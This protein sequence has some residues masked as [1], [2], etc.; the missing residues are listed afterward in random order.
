[1]DNVAT[2]MRMLEDI[3]EKQ[4]ELSDMADAWDGD[5]PC[6]A[7]TSDPSDQFCL[8]EEI[9]RDLKAFRQFVVDNIE[10]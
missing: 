9:E 4:Q 6:A 5:D 8:G 7:A 10:P 2:M 1:M 3:Q